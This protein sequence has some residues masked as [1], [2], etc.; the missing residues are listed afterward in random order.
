MHKYFFGSYDMAKSLIYIIVYIIYS[1][2]MWHPSLIEVFLIYLLRY[3]I[4]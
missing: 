2:S 3:N 1:E 4:K